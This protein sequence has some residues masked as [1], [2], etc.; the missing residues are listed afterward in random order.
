MDMKSESQEISGPTIAKAKSPQHVKQ[1]AG[2]DFLPNADLTLAVSFAD[3]GN[4][5]KLLGQVFEIV[6]VRC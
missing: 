2:C 3:F 1:H 5:A 4:P 6:P